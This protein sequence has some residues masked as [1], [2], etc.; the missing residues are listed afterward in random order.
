M[1]GLIVL[2]ASG[3]SGES[4]TGQRHTSHST[5]Q[6]SLADQ[7]KMPTGKSR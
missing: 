7:M 5:H 2:P 1:A 4:G 6:I 3:N